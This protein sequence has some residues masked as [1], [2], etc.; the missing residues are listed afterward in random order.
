ME[1]DVGNVTRKS[2]Q[3]DTVP[4]NKIPKANR[5]SC[6]GYCFP[7]VKTRRE[8]DRWEVYPLK[9][10]SHTGMAL[11]DYS[12]NIGVPPVLKTDNAQSE[13]GRMWSDHCHH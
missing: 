3:E 11:Q 8:S 10:E 2:G 1:K 6:I 13:V 7:T 9:T 12:R 5:N 4:W